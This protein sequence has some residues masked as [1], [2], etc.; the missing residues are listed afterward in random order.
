M[1]VF[2]SVSVLCSFSQGRKPVAVN[3]EV[4]F[5]F[6]C[7]LF[8]CLLLFDCCVC[9][10]VCLFYWESIFSRLQT[11]NEQRGDFVVVVVVV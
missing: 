9:L 3:K 10:V 6:V 11:C 7:L 5:L 4:S 2:P 8:V 1:F